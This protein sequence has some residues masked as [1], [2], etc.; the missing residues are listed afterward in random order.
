MNE[1]FSH[2]GVIFSNHGGPPTIISGG[3]L[4]DETVEGS[5]GKSIKTLAH[6]F[7]VIE[8]A[9]KRANVETIQKRD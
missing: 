4:I 7:P 2:L 6:S 1:Q 8:I 9:L 5:Q 3:S